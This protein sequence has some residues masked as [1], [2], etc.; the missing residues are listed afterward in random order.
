MSAPIDYLGLQVFT[1]G[2][3]EDQQEEGDLEAA[4]IFGDLNSLACNAEKSALAVKI[5]AAINE[6]RSEEGASVEVLCSNPDFNK[7]PNEKI[8][9]NAWFTGFEDRT[10]AGA[11]LLAC[12]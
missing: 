8:S 10:F 5:L 12:L 1:Q 3:A 9:V 2:Q 4:K 11:T 7:Q 6:L